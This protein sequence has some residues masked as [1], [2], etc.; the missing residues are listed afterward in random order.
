[1]A[2]PALIFDLGGNS[3]NPSTSPPLPARNAGK[4]RRSFREIELQSEARSVNRPYAVF[5][6]A[7]FPPHR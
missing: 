4:N 6:E 1:M 3:T 2:E 7:G 5:A